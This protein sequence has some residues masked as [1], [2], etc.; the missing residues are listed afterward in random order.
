M[1]RFNA[2]TE[3]NDRYVFASNANPSPAKPQIE[4]EHELGTTWMT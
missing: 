2:I 4:P 3:A 1:D